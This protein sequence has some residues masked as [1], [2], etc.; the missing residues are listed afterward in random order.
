MYLRRTAASNLEFSIVM[1][2]IKV[3]KTPA[4]YSRFQTK[5]RRRREG[6]TDYYA[7]KR[8]IAQDKTKYNSP[9]YRLVVRFTN[10]D[11]VCQIVYSTITADVV[12]AAAY[13]HELKNYGLKVP[14]AK[15]YSA[16]YATGL[17]VARRVLNKLG[18]DTAYV[19]V[20][21]A[22][23][24]HY[25]VEDNGERRPFF[26]ILDTGLVCTSTGARVFGAMKGAA[27]GGLEIP[28]NVRRFPGYDDE[29]SK[30]D[31]AVLRKY[32][33]GGHIADYMRKLSDDD[34]DRYKRQFSRY[35][36]A[37][38][39]ADDVEGMW[40][41]VHSKIRANPKF[42]PTKKP[43]KPVHKSFQRPKKNNKQRKNR[44]KQRLAAA[45]AAQ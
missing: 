34:Q 42:T 1:G 16:A 12:I 18:M 38:V 3:V 45:A 11:V 28:H 30:F 23:G 44:V 14:G 22:D 24:K 26:V 17:L 10:T 2:Y 13:S 21:E 32:I 39:T 29:N 31:A 6:R 36:T 27:D 15:S 43:E 25:I 37:G 35:I 7:R 41:G 33:F 4:Y 19:G 20:K 40:K 8:L 9:K 5:F